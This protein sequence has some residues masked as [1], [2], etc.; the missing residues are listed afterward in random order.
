[1]SALHLIIDGAIAEIR[2]DNPSKLNALTPDMLA[3]LESHCA[4]LE[5]NSAVR[6]VI[7]TA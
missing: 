3:A 5:R 7:L 1:M 2:L 4:E 6:A